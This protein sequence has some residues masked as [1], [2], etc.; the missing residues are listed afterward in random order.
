MKYSLVQASCLFDNILIFMYAQIFAQ[1]SLCKDWNVNHGQDRAGK[2]LPAFDRFEMKQHIISTNCPLPFVTPLTLFCPMPN[3]WIL[4]GTPVT[5]PCQY[6]WVSFFVDCYMHMWFGWLGFHQAY[7]W[8]DTPHETTSKV[9]QVSDLELT[10]SGG[11]GEYKGAHFG[12][13]QRLP[14]EEAECTSSVMT[15]MLPT[16]FTGSKLCSAIGKV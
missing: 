9:P 5:A 12:V 6:P 3:I 2:S 1:G 10:S 14:A 15:E 16:I 7:A 13:F 8:I 4:R 11:G